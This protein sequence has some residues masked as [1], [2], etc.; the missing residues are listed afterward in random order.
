MKRQRHSKLNQ[1][2]HL[3]EGL[4]CNT[5]WLAAKGYS[6]QLVAKYVANGWLERVGHGAYTRPGAPRKWQHVV[7]SLQTQGLPL[8]P[9]GETA[10]ALLGRAHQLPLS[11]RTVVHLYGPARLP[12]WVSRAAA[13]TKFRHHVGQLFTE[14]AGSSATIGTSGSGFETYSWGPWDWTLRISSMERA[15]LELLQGVPGELGFDA[16]DEL[17][18][19]LQSLRPKAMEAL[20]GRCRSFKVRRLALWLA[21]RH[22]QP[23]LSKLDPLGLDM[24]RGKRS[25]APGGRLI[26][27]FGITVPQHLADGV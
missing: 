19:G 17:A 20:L 9:G 25:L 11:G 23:W 10:L 16:A 6:R 7:Y 14:K 8:H 18:T 13:K 24:G 1:L 2:Q 15:W 27:K 3:P 4:V 22:H 21:E 26:K 5:Q 12:H